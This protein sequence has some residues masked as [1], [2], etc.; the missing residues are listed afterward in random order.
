MLA[1]YTGTVLS[2]LPELSIKNIIIVKPQ[3]NV[4][5]AAAYSAFDTAERVRHLDKTGMLTAV[6]KGDIAEVC[7]KVGNVF[8]QFIDVPDR[9]VIKSIMRK[10]GAVCACMSGS[11]PS[12]FGIFE[13]DTNAENCLEELKKQFPESYLCQ[14]TQSGC[15]I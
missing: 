14:S 13:D 3:Q 4:S 1:P 15:E 7:G 9:V 11:G 6:L 10:H 12:V 8:E 5:T 2:H